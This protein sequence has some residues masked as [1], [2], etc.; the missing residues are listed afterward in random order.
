MKKIII[1]LTL[2]FL[3]LATTPMLAQAQDETMPQAISGQI[4]DCPMPLPAT[5]IEGETIVCGQITVPEDWDDPNSTP[6]T[7]TY[8]RQFSTSQ[9]PFADPVLFFAGGPGGSVLASIGNEHFD[10]PYFRTTRDVILF[11][12]RGNRFSSDLRCPAEV[13]AVDPEVAAEELA[14]LGEYTFTPDSDPDEAVDYMAQAIEIQGYGLCPD[15]LRKQGVDL[16]EYSTANTVRDT[17]AL[18][19]HLGDAEYNL[20]G[21]SY[22]TTVT[23]AILDYYENSAFEDLPT[24]RSALIDGV[25]PLNEPGGFIGQEFNLIEVI[26]G[27]FEG[28]EADSACGAAYPDIQQRTVDLLNELETNPL[29][30]DDGAEISVDDL[31]FILQTTGADRRNDVIPFLPR[32][33]AEL[34][35]GETGTYTVVSGILD[36]SVILTPAA[37]VSATPFDPVSF[38]TASIAAELRSLAASLEGL[39][40]ESAALSEAVDKA[41]TLLELYLILLNDYLARTGVEERQQ[42]ATS[43]GAYIG[44]PE[45]QTRQGLI[46][47][48]NGLTSAT[49]GAELASIA[50]ALDA[51]DVELLFETL[52]DNEFTQPLIQ[53]DRLTNLTVKCNDRITYTDITAYQERLRNL[54]TPQLLTGNDSAA[55]NVALCR[56]LNLG[57]PE[58]DPPP[59]GVVSDV[60]TLVF[61]STLDF[62]TPVSSGELAFQTLTNAEMVIFP[63]S[64]HGA[65][66]YFDC[67][68]DIANAFVTYP[69]VEFDRSCVEDLK[70]NYVLPGD[71]LPLVPAAVE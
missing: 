65:V 13:E 26:L 19:N 41:E 68:R 53:L 62:Q 47:I 71:D 51:A 63:G 37:E 20:F 43:I 34:E 55:Q 50:N 45:A 15:Y 21:I 66:R 14:A 33:I 3:A 61:N 17:I 24:L 67:A 44:N 49:V 69:D 4:I 54:D 27:I 40:V 60:R 9:S 18:M 8:A 56:V 35:S 23:L 58:G 32:M 64:G 16:A 6:I 39:S 28:C 22:G 25:F 5:E 31:V 1:L 2:L 46:N 10:F 29:E 7:L 70:P 57:A 36:N 59:P 38:E 52:T 48:S 42:F 30:L 11:D 12:Q